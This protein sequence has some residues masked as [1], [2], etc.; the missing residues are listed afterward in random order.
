MLSAIL[1]L[2]VV[3]MFLARHCLAPIFPGTRIRV[4]QYNLEETEGVLR[5]A[6]S[7]SL[8]NRIPSFMLQVELDLLC[9]KLFASHLASNVLRAK[10][11]SW[12]KY[13]P[14]LWAIS[15][16]AA[17]SRWQVKELRTTIELAI[18]TERQRRYN[19]AILDKRAVISSLTS[20]GLW[21]VLCL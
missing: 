14:F 11:L 9:A 18:E 1:P 17:R 16:K 4:L 7:E 21:T 13:L 6:L 20:T 10:N 5:L 2:M 19:D 15:L 8:G 12:R 3:L